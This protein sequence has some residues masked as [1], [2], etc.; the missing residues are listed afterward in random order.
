MQS[1]FT[2]A[3][4]ASI[5]QVSTPDQGPLVA[6]FLD[7]VYAARGAVAVHCKAGLGRTGTL[8]AVYLMRSHGFTARAAM[9]WLRLMRPGSVIGE[10]QGFLCTV[11]RIREEKRKAARRVALLWGHL[12]SSPD[13]LG[14]AGR[15]RAAPVA[16]DVLRVASGSAVPWA[17]TADAAAAEMM[18]R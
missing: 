7:I 17:T 9:G 13:V 2:F 3:T 8:I 18:E 5:V 12:Q 1:L 15:D 6:A 14:P 16:A 10:Q 11:Q 4:V